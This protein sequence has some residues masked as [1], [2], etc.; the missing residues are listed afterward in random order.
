MYTIRRLRTRHSCIVFNSYFLVYAAHVVT[1]GL[2]WRMWTQPS[3]SHTQSPE[4]TAINTAIRVLD[5]CGQR[6]TFARKYSLLIKEL[7]R[8]LD[9]GSSSIKRISP[10]AGSQMTG[11]QSTTPQ[12]SISNDETLGQVGS[13]SH[14]SGANQPLTN[15]KL[16]RR[17]LSADFAGIDFDP[18]WLEQPQDSS[19][20]LFPGT[21]L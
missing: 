16:K 11:I 2:A 8:Q 6:N 15:V 4:S 3:A 5:F 12:G 10:Y 19:E 20:L 9:R 14:E 7:Q 17:S 18:S 13:G 21:L 1:L